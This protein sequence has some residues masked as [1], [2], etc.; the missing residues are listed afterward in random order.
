MNAFE[1]AVRLTD[2]LNNLLGNEP[3]G[4][5]ATIR[6]RAAVSVER[7]LADLAEHGVDE[8]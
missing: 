1:I 6:V 7:L 3:A 5:E 2:I 4:S 8:D